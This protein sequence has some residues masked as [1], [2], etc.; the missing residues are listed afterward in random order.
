[1]SAVG[2]ILAATRMESVNGTPFGDPALCYRLFYNGEHCIACYVLPVSWP[3]DLGK[4]QALLREEA[5][6]A[7]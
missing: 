6:N 2:N 5:T 4:V 7:R 3:D 1:M